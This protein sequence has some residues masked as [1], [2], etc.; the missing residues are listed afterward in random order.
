MECV[1]SGQEPRAE[2]CLAYETT[3]L[4]YGE[5]W[6]DE[7][8]AEPHP[9]AF[10]QCDGEERA[11]RR[12]EHRVHAARNRREHDLERHAN[13]G[14]GIRI[15]IHQV[16]SEHRAAERS[17][18]GT[19]DGD[20]QLFARDVDANGGSSILIVGDRL[21]R[22][23]TDAT[24]DPAPDEQRTKPDD[25]GDRIEIAFVRKL[26]RVPGMTDASWREPK[27]AAGDVAR[28]HDRQQHDLAQG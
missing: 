26:Q 10:S 9:Q 5:Y 27:R 28:R 11:H 14:K 18:G 21:E 15:E 19:D 23:A 16:L 7:V 2:H 8:G 3:K 25:E 22:L 1:A 12:P 20:A 24:V 4:N 17:Q 6:S 13:P